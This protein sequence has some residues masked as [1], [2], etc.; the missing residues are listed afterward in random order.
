MTQRT[1]K[2]ITLFLAATLTASNA[3]AFWGVGDVTYDPSAY[4][5]LVAIVAQLKEMYQATTDSL[6]SMRSMEST[7][8]NT[9]R[10]YE[11]VRNINLKQ[12]VKR[13][14]FSGIEHQINTI[15]RDMNTLQDKA[16]LSGYQQAQTSHINDLKRLQQV[17]QAT[18]ESAS[19]AAGGISKRDADVI[20][21]QSTATLAAL[22]AE[23]AGD[24][25]VTAMNRD[26]A[27]RQQADMMDATSQ[28]MKAINTKQQ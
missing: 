19:A 14:D 2:R 8:K 11:E 25:R 4:G 13:L 16:G 23:A 20:T 12:S 17:Q 1:H 27:A 10:D 18:E 24:R 6:D 3:H 5:E 9:Y 26:A 22:A 15:N 21:A 7:L 28:A